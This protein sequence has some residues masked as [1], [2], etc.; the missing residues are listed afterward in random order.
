MWTNFHL[1]SGLLEAQYYLRIR[2]C[3]HA[4]PSST[5]GIAA[6]IL[7]AISWECHVEFMEVRSQFR[8]QCRFVVLSVKIIRSVSLDKTSHSYKL[9]LTGRMGQLYTTP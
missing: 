5:V 4:V 2:G 7:N 1:G 8:L 9:D 3:V 6:T